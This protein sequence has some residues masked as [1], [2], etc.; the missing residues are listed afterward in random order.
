[1]KSSHFGINKFALLLLTAALSVGSI[2]NANQSSKSDIQKQ[3]EIIYSDR[4]LP[5]P[6]IFTVP[7]LVISPDLK[8]LESFKGELQMGG[9][10]DGGGNAVGGTLFDFY[11]NEGSVEITVKELIQIEPQ[12]AIILQSLNKSVPLLARES[13]GLGDH[14]KRFISHRKI[15]LEPKD[16]NS[17]ACLNQSMVSV[18]GQKAVACQSDEEVRFNLSWLVQTDST[19]RAGL[20]LHEMILA[21]ARNKNYTLNL[22]KNTLE[23]R[24]R[25]LNRDIFA[26][27]NDKNINLNRSLSELFHITSL[28]ASTHQIAESLRPR[29]LAA[30]RQHCQGKPVNWERSFADIKKD[31]WFYDEFTSIMP[32]FL[33]AML[34]YGTTDLSDDCILLSID[35]TPIRASQGR[36]LSRK[37]L[38]DLDQAIN[39]YESSYRRWTTGG[40][41]PDVIK[42]GL[43]IGMH[44]I[45]LNASLCARN[46]KDLYLESLNYARYKLALKKV[47]VRFGDLLEP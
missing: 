8:S 18:G 46:K 31:I 3:I 32:S 38:A 9:V 40:Y 33:S 25:A 14:L 45:S 24:V 2:S 26:S 47:G 7:D 22:D 10:S 41:S 21:M 6:N 13:E 43:A 30:L 36:G 27:L 39:T 44:H 42:N 4:N 28:N 16:I 17:H 37:C 1:M 20:I 19:N 5:L 23:Q 12:V 29:A 15:F 35:S 11:E 34:K